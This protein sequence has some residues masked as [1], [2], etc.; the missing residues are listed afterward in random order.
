MPYTADAPRRRRSSDELRAEI[1]GWGADLDPADRPSFPRERTDLETGAHWD[2]PP[3]QELT[4]F[5]ERSIEHGRITPVFGTAQPIRG[6]SG[7]VRRFAYRFS[8]GRARH[9]LLLLAADRIESAEHHARSLF[10]KHP[11]DPITQTGISGEFMADG[12]K[13]RFGKRRSDVKHTWMD[14]I[15][16]LG[17]WVL[18]SFAIVKLV[19]KLRR[20][21]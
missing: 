1:P 5:R 2:V 6:V 15:I 13:S 16:V 20:R 8:E 4:G 18:V 12:I 9:W 7:P 10:T 11:D 21:R 19:R 17:P 14:P 3:Q